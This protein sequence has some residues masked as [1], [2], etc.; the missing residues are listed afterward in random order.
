MKELQKAKAK[1]L[2]EFEYKGKKYVKKLAKTGMVIY[3]GK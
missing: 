2:E 3:K 1:G